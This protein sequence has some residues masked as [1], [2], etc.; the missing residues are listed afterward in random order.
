MS[1]GYEL[2]ALFRSTALIPQQ[3]NRLKPG[4]GRVFLYG[5]RMIL[6]T[7]V[8][9][10][11]MAL[12]GALVGFALHI[13]A[14]VVEIRE[15]EL[16]AT[17]TAKTTIARYVSLAPYKFILKAG[18]VVVASIAVARPEMAIMDLLSA[19]GLGWMAD[20]AGNHLKRL[21]PK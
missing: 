15:L 12:T 10:V 21:A 5:F 19:A 14:K 2:A 16:R 8:L 17:G 11:L 9:S 18:M 13:L 4:F 1:S 3:L 6:G 7:P 20:S